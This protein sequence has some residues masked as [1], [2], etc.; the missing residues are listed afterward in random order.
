MAQILEQLQINN[1][2]FLQFALF[3]AFFFIL[4]ELYLKPFQR[5][6]EKRNH[7][8]KDDVQFATDLLKEVDAKLA[9]YEK[10][11]SQARQEARLSYE[12]VIAEVRTKEDAAIHSHRDEIKKD[13][14][15]VSQQLHE[16][17]LKVE[18][19]L[20][21]QVSAMADS[22]VQKTLAGK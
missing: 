5:L 8:L 19:E 2:L 3:I 10:E 4:S 21:A 15:K 20:K 18:V 1:T 6:I 14:Q 7:K 17:K 11:I 13:Y 22:F 12:R 16:E 9:G